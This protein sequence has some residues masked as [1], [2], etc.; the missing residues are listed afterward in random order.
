MLLRL[1]DISKGYGEPDKNNFREVLNGLNLE[2]SEGR[3]IAIAGPS[4][5]GKTALL[6][7]FGTL[8]KPDRG[9][10]WFKEQDI[11]RYSVKGLARFRNRELGFVFQL[12]HLL[13]KYTLWENILMQVLPIY[14]TAGKA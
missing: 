6:N 10:I 8:D 3:K 9:E 13:P 5:S 7:L 1:K 4:G 2:V 12:H 11:T 14:K